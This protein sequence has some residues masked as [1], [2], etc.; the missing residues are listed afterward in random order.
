MLFCLSKK[1]NCSKGGLVDQMMAMM[2]QY[3][4]NLE[5]LVKE[6]TMLLEETQQRADRLLRQLLPRYCAL[7]KGRS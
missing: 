3:A 2:E 4:N 6:R 5:K 7:F 1:D